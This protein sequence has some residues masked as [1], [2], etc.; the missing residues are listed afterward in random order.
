[1]NKVCAFAPATIA[2]LNV[3]FDVLGLALSSVGD[4]VEVSANGLKE[5]RITEIISEIPLPTDPKKNSCTYVI[6]K[7]Q[8]SLGVDT[9]VDVRIKKGFASGSGL[10]SSSAS[11]AAAA[12]AYNAFLGNPFQIEELL[13]FAAEG[14]RIACGSAHLDNVSPALLGGI[15]LLHNRKP[16]RL[17]MPKELYAVSFFPKIEVKTSSSRSIVA[18]HASLDVVAKQVSAMGAFVVGLYSGDYQL[19]NSASVDYL[20]EPSRKIL[21]PYFDEM[22]AVAMG[23]GGITFGI[24]GSGPSVFALSPT[25]MI[26]EK[27]RNALEAIYEGSGI[28][29]LSFVED[30]KNGKGAKLCEY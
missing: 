6:E 19:M 21:I 13:P 16:V 17:P 30:L 12:Y 26:A 29:T 15:V 10:G 11:S 22:R 1:M 7:M 28:R 27:I 9:Y 24:S 8:A 2:N 18:Q 23:A 25:L 14:E 5:N 3:G 4:R 20:V